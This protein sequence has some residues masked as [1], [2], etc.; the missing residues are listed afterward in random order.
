[1]KSIFPDVEMASEDGL[2][3][4]GGHLDIQTLTDAYSRGIFPWPVEEGYPLTWFAPDPRGM[5]KVENCKFSKSL[6]KFIKKMDYEVKFNTDF[7]RVITECA[8]TKRKHEY[9]TW[10]Y[11][12]II[13]GYSNL[14]DVGKAYCVSVYHEGHLVGG[15]YGACFGEIIS[16][17]SMFY[18]KDN[19]SKVA[20]YYLLKAVERAKIPFVDTQ[21]VTPIVESFGGELVDRKIYMKLLHSLNKEVSRDS[22]FY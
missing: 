9:G 6:L 18:K 17:E 8:M 7:R 12:N 22:I 14:F 21:M 19:A 3:A 10:I 15:L 5:I 11:E 2:L 20:L 13:E 4:V 1:M 16:G